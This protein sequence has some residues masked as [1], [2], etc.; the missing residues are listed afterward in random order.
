MTPV[1]YAITR[2]FGPA[3]LGHIPDDLEPTPT[4]PPEQLDEPQKPESQVKFLQRTKIPSHLIARRTPPAPPP[5]SAR[6]IEVGRKLEAQLFAE[7]EAEAAAR[8]VE[9]IEHE[10]RVRYLAEAQERRRLG[11]P[12]DPR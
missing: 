2:V 8:R 4:P 1:Q 6:M 12:P 3:F 5:L 9:Q 7:A 10:N 11:L